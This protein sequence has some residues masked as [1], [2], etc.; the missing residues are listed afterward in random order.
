[1]HQGEREIA[2]RCSLG[3]KPRRRVAPTD[4]HS[5]PGIGKEDT[6]RVGS[7]NLE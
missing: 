4:R 3:E 2:V 7:R 6:E 1:M 5:I